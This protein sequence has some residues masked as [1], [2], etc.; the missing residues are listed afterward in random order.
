MIS[1]RR[2]V[3]GIILSFVCFLVMLPVSPYDECHNAVVVL[4]VVQQIVIMLSVVT[5]SDVVGLPV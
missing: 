2:K 4:G 3:N 1:V 5:Q